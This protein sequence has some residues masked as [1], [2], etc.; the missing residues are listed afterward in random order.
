MDEVWI[1]VVQCDAA[2]FG[3]L[4]RPEFHFYFLLSV[5][6]VSPLAQQFVVRVVAIWCDCVPFQT[7]PGLLNDWQMLC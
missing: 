1:K 6:S 5:N 4:S 7:L 2:N 3:T